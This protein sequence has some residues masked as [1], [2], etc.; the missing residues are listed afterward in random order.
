LRS[1]L[2]KRFSKARHLSK[3][4][5][6]WLKSGNE[7]KWFERVGTFLTEQGIHFSSKKDVAIAIL[8][9]FPAFG[10][11]SGSQVAKKCNTKTD[12]YRI[13]G[14]EGMEIYKNSITTNNNEK[15]RDKFFNAPIIRAIWEKLAPSMS[16]KDFFKGGEAS[17]N[18][19]ITPTYS[20]ITKIM[21]EKYHLQMCPQWCRRFPAEI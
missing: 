2:S 21:G 19:R 8:L 4:Y 3:G 10:P 13:L 12:V 11:S 18:H 16:L 1:Y 20:Q 7:A 15:L 5:H 9:I 17:A 14:K 6:H